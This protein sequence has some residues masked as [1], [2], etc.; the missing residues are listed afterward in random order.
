MKGAVGQLL[1]ADCLGWADGLAEMTIAAGTTAHT[2]LCFIGLRNTT[3]VRNIM[4]MGQAHLRDEFLG[5]PLPFLALELGK[6]SFGGILA[7]AQGV[8]GKTGAF[9]IT[10]C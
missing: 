3:L 7:S 1:A 10:D 2:T 9:N 5:K 4:S 8:S 6:Q